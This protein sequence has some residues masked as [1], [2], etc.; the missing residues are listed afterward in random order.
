MTGEGTQL[1]YI[2]EAV[3][4]EGARPDVETAHPDNPMNYKAGWGYMMLTYFL[5]NQGNGTFTLHAIAADK[6]HEI[7]IVRLVN[8][9]PLETWL[10]G[11]G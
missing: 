6:V 1:I 7:E 2:G 3:L 5:P 11:H 4:V 9:A 8:G 10:S